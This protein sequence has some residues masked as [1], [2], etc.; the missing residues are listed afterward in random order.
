[1]MHEGC[2]SVLFFSQVHTDKP[3]K[4]RQVLEMRDLEEIQVYGNPLPDVASAANVK[5]IGVNRLLDLLKQAFLQVT[6]APRPWGLG[7]GS[8]QQRGVLGSR[9][10]AAARL[11]CEV[12]AR[13][14]SPS[15]RGLRGGQALL[16]STRCRQPADNPSPHLNP[17]F[18]FRK[19]R[20]EISISRY[21]S[22]SS[23][24][25]PIQLGLQVGPRG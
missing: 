4:H 15:A 21:G 1:M 24:N 10:N 19:A 18:K 2:T 14:A 9:P 3:N 25:C 6:T 11:V 23:I 20:I 5:G 16:P 22:A 13:W 17:L 7:F 8:Q 12:S